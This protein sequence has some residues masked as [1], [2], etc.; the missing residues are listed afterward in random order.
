MKE[1]L[2]PNPL[3]RKGGPHVSRHPLCWW[4]TG[5]LGSSGTEGGL[6]HLP[7]DNGQSKHHQHWNYS[8]IL[9]EGEG[10][11]LGRPQSLP[12]VPR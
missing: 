11:L 9:G 6:S 4:S 12:G 8:A 7:L 5:G 2:G 3:E 1:R 10:R